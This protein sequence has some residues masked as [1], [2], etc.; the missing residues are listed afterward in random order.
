MLTWYRETYEATAADAASALITHLWTPDGMVQDPGA[1]RKLSRREDWRVHYLQAYVPKTTT[2]Y[3]KPGVVGQLILGMDWPG[4]WMPLVMP[5]HG[6]L[7]PNYGLIYR[8]GPFVATHGIGWAF[9]K[10]ALA[11][12]DK[13]ILRALYEPIKGALA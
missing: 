1:S 2:G 11:D 5:H 4:S 10:G 6:G 8:G 9:Y 13:V 12:T 3:L 7:H